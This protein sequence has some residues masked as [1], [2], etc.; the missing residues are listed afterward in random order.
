MGRM[1]FTGRPQGMG[2]KGAWVFLDLPEGSADVFG[3]KARVSVKLTVGGKT[4]HVSAFPDGEGRHQLNFNKAMQAA[5]GW[6]SGKAVDVVVEADTAPRTVTLPKDVKAAL[7]R[8]AKARSTFENLAPSHR[9]AYVDWITE[10]KRP[11]TR[12]KRIAEAVARLAKG[13]R[14]WD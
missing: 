4:F 6:S 10:A 7:A 14:F 1:E 11:E 5:A 3:T 12:A 13:G 8:S 9:K 2:P